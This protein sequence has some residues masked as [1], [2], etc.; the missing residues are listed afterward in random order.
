MK[1]LGPDKT[2]ADFYIASLFEKERQ[3]AK[4]PA[5]PHHFYSN[6]PSLSPGSLSYKL[7]GCC[8]DRLP[9]QGGTGVAGFRQAISH[10]V[11]AVFASSDGLR[12]VETC[13]VSTLLKN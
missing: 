12:F 7:M 4:F 13:G 9:V 8:I 1:V 2:Q 6:L 10:C 5:E 3:F 11:A